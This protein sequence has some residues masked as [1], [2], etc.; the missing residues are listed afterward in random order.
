MEDFQ[1]I[2]SSQDFKEFKRSKSKFLWPIVILFVCYYLALPLMAGYAKDL[3]GSF[4]FSNIT[5][6]YLFGIS[7][8]IVAWGLAFVYVL[9]ARKFDQRA[10]EILSKYSKYSKGA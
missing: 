10:S 6:G 4:V 7:Y 8:Y 5:F 3:M 2:A 9:R 1:K